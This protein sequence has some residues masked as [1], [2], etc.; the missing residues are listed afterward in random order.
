MSQDP[1][2]GFDPLN[3]DFFESVFKWTGI[4]IGVVDS[5]GFYW[6]INDAWAQMLGYA[7]EEL[8][9]KSIRD[10]SCPDDA[11]KSY[12]SLNALIK[13]EI[14]SYRFEKR[15]IRKDRKEIFCDLIATPFKNS[16]GEIVGVI[17]VMIE[18][19]DRKY[20]EQQLLSLKELYA[21]SALVHQS[22]LQQKELNSLL[23]KVCE[24]G[25]SYGGFVAAMVADLDRETRQLHIRTTACPDP[26]IK[27]ML[28]VL[29]LSS[30]PESPAGIGTVGESVR[31]G[32][33]VFINDFL[34]HPNTG[35]WKE[36][37]R[38][39]NVRSV[40]SFPLKKRGEVIGTLIV[41]SDKVG[42][43]QSEVL[44]LL[45]SMS[46]SISYCID[47]LDHRENLLL[48][49]TVFREAI[50]GVLITD[51][52]GK[53]LMANKSFHEMTGFLPEDIIGEN[54]RVIHSG[55]HD[56]NLFRKIFKTISSSCKWEGEVW[57]RR[58]NGQIRLHRLSVVGIRSKEGSLTH[59]I[60]FLSDITAQREEE[61]RMRRLAFHDPLT[62]LPN[63]MLFHDRLDQ[64]L[65]GAKRLDS[66]IG[67]C[68]LDLDDFKPVNDQYGH[69]A[70]DE[71]LKEIALRLERSIRES[72][73]VCR[74]GG[75]E[76][77]ILFSNILDEN[78]MEKLGDQLLEEVSK[79]FAWGDDYLYVTASAGLALYPHDGKD[80][81]DLL[82]HA[83]WAMYQAKKYGRNRLFRKP[84]P[85]GQNDTED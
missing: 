74:I 46:E 29:E 31:T 8:L 79:P 4:G 75:D 48:S 22:L 25:V 52:H 30:D 45:T 70:G 44:S 57:N 37:A 36:R 38:Y 39:A 66:S 73:T 32:R 20:L 42:Y 10:V 58:Q 1:M 15:F 84:A 9:T 85:T 7:K 69:H 65:R 23:V 82:T 3:K 72:D 40:A 28:D 59:F 6:R 51:Y 41:L 12:D 67:I 63:R 2:D 78:E 62:G 34:A 21:G 18:I 81:T 53:V 60:G 19:T 43:F 33:P 77:I 17:G 76:F 50:E 14:D 49:S 54:V 64:A 47:S 71:L 55:S 13:G 24:I 11:E 83:D 27:K 35:Q 5:A 61:D 80:T 68:Y 56:R 26:V 16:N